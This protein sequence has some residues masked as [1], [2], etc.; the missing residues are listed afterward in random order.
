MS[1]KKEFLSYTIP[2]VFSF[3]LTGVYCF[4]DAFFVG[5]KVGDTG[6]AAINV[7]YCL[8]A[9]LQ[10]LGSGIGLG[11]SVKYSIYKAQGKDK[12]SQKYLSGAF[13]LMTIL[14][15]IIVVP[16]ILFPRQLLIAIGASPYVAQI[17]VPYLLI[18]SYGSLLQVYSTVLMPIVR[19]NQ[20]S[21]ISMTAGIFGGL[22]NA[23]FDYLFVWVF[24]MGL[25]GASA[26]TLVGQAFALIMLVSFM[27]K[28]KKLILKVDFKGIGRVFK[29]I[30]IIGITPFGLTTVPNIT[31]ILLNKATLLHGGERGL[32]AYGCIAYLTFIALLA[33]QGVGDG[34]QPL[35][36][37]YH[38]KDDK[39]SLK[40]VNRYTYIMSLGFALAFMAIEILL[41]NKLGAFMG[42]LPDTAIIVAT[43]LPIF[44]LAFPFQA[45]SRSASSILYATENV[46]GSY[47]ITYTEPVFILVSLLAL[48]ATY[49]LN[50]VWIACA[51][52][53]GLVMLLSVF[54]IL[55]K[56]KNKQ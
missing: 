7:S 36:S 20:G 54:L 51:T 6:L 12:E 5:N 37:Y 16:M 3:V 42:A 4:V 41:R 39:E 10:A 18:Q 48:G 9:L 52:G 1:L 31:V 43:A 29:D 35:I 15:L 50:G 47:L 44:A 22:V 21:V 34:A 2:S 27:L 19:N 56:S 30:L 40:K 24:D 45:F 13:L 38:G 46:L 11:A 32:A 8:I 49:G 33:L 17:G 53:Q 25:P 28:K 55:C 14:D 23:F 26:A